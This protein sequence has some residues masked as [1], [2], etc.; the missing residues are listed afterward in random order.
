MS[1][2]VSSHVEDGFAVLDLSGTLTLGPSLS[3]LREGARKV[4][5]TPKLFGLIL[6][7][8][9]VTQTD[10]SGLGELT[11][12]YTLATKKGCPIWL[13]EASP[14][15]KKMLEMTKLDGLLPSA[16]TVASAKAEIMGR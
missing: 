1:L 4:L 11:V 9:E 14:S 6:R 13:A 15:L 5:G 8:S 3:T 16:D 7:V 10:S 12:V 2:N